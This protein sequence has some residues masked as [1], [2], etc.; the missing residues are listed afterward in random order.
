MDP[1]PLPPPLPPMEVA[2][3][4]IAQV[5]TPIPVLL[6]TPTH[7]HPPYS[8]MIT[9]AI[10]A[11][12]EKDGSS[13][14]AIAKY[15]ERVYS[16]LPP[17]HSALLTQ[18]LKRL[19]NCGELVMVKHSYALPRSPTQSQPDPAG[20][21]LSPKRRPGR[22]PKPKLEQ[23]PQFQFQPE[24]SM[25]QFPQLHFQQ[26]SMPHFQPFVVPEVHNSGPESVFASL[27][28]VDAPPAPP[29]PPQPTPATKR[30]PGRPKRIISEDKV[31]A[32]PLG[33]RRPGR[34]PKGN[35]P[36]LATVSGVV[37]GRP[38][39]RPKKNISTGTTGI[40]RGRPKASATT[41][42]KKL[43]RPRG[44][45]AKNAQLGS[46]GGLVI[47]PITDNDAPAAAPLPGNNGVVP[48]P[49]R[50]GRPPTK[51]ADGLLPAP[52]PRGRLPRSSADGVKKPRKLSGK[53]LGRP[54]KNALLAA[55]NAPDSQHLEALQDLQGK[56]EQLKSRIK[57][58]ASVLRP[59]LN[60][61]TA[62]AALQDLEEFAA[63]G[64]NPVQLP[65]PVPI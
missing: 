37:V 20:N 34:P 41:I 23:Q 18:H 46:A 11:L 64:V 45:P 56:L 14:Q 65:P 39:G 49:K 31:P 47:V 40:P 3:A 51:Y 28:L 17:N 7:N 25:G 61:E 48:M 9:A 53:P 43:G 15:I 59:C 29:P 24:D 58:T 1:L 33:V 6:P 2:A 10:T 32:A 50:R 4:R 13:R 38:R 5:A 21:A 57:E 19:K 16:D 44:R 60:S 35:Q 63:N 36:G 22:P 26:P 54:R 42:A 12:K 30:R 62:M 27:G 55:P 8:Q 52:K